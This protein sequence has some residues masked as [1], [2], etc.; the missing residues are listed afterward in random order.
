MST[1]Q[2]RVG[3]VLMCVGVV[4]K[5]PCT[6]VCSNASS[7]GWAEVDQEAAVTARIQIPVAIA[8]NTTSNVGP[9]LLQW[10]KAALGSIVHAWFLL[11][12][13]VH[14]FEI[15]SVSKGQVHFAVSGGRQGGQN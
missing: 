6:G 12:W 13:T 1:R 15:E 7:G 9:R 4:L 14:M 3:C 8:I 10:K 11:S 2:V 5:R